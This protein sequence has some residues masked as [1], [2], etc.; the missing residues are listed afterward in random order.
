VYIADTGP[1]SSEKE[2]LYELE[3]EFDLNVYNF[4]NPTGIAPSGKE[5]IND[6]NEEYFIQ[7][8]SDYEMPQNA[9]VLKEILNKRQS[10]AGVGVLLADIHLNRVFS[11]AADLHEY[12][13]NLYR[14][15]K[16]QK[17]MERV[18]GHPFI[19]FEY[20]TF[21]GMFRRKA[22]DDYNYDP[23]YEV[24]RE[25]VDLYFGLNKNGWKFGTCPAVVFNHDHEENEEY[26][27]RRYNLTK[28][29]EY[30]LEKWGYNDIIVKDKWFSSNTYRDDCTIMQSIKNSYINSR[31][32]K[33]DA[34]DNT[35]KKIYDSVNN[36]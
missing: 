28:P 32:R 16:G 8:P 1:N 20:N 25:H 29:T 5:I 7:V 10:L 13:G 14:E 26:S 9:S 36:I 23:N 21:T 4:E 24:G 22:F 15:I 33:Y 19:E 17:N 11:C 2:K 12:N 30:F 6:I 34:I 27:E 35:V 3:Y 18:A 31:L